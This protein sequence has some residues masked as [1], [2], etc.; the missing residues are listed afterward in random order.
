[1]NF[2]AKCACVVVSIFVTVFMLS[3]LFAALSERRPQ[4]SKSDL[5]GYK[6]CIQRVYEFKTEEFQN[7]WREK[8]KELYVKD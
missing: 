3:A 1:M 7:K 2:A 6:S 8:C 5:Q 4:E